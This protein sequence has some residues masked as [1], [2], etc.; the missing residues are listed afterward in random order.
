MESY[1][2]TSTSL[3]IGE[4]GT[5][6]GGLHVK[7]TSEVIDDENCILVMLN[8]KYVCC[9]PILLFLISFFVQWDLILHLYSRVKVG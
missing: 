9:L 5:R 7:M 6:L 1:P 8:I 3:P 2:L 4:T